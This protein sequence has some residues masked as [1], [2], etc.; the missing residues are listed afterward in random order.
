LLSA[1]SMPEILRTFHSSQCICDLGYLNSQCCD[2]PSCG[3]CC[4][5]KSSFKSFA[6]GNTHNDGRHGKGI[7]S[8][9]NPA[10]ADRHATSCTSS[11]Y[12]VVIACNVVMSQAKT[13]WFPQMQRVMSVS[14][15]DGVFVTDADTII[16]QHVIL[17]TK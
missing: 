5:L 6:F 12:R 4:I 13:S 15:E 8:Y 1:N 2:K 10:H 11:P 3:I 16:A 7:Y 14:D 9:Q 17:Y